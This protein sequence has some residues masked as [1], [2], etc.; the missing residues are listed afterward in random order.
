ME[1]GY[2]LSIIFAICALAVVIS[3]AMRYRSG[4]IDYLDSDA[5]WHTLL[6][7]ECYNETPISQHLFLPIVSLGDADD[8]GIPWGA[9]IPDV[10]GNYYYTSFSPMGYF[11]P[12]LF[13]KIFHLSASER[14]LYIFNTLLFLISTCLL[15][16]LISIIYRDNKHELILCLSGGLLYVFMPEL[17]HGMGM[18]YWHQSVLQV[19]LLLQ[20]IAF[21]KYAV[22]GE[23]AY[24]WLFY[25]LAVFNPYTEWTGY[26]AN[27]GFAFAELILYWKESKKKA[28]GRAM[29]L[30]ALTILAF[31]LFSAHY[32]L[33]TDAATYFMA[34]KNRFMARNVTTDV[35]ILSVIKGY[36]DSFLY[37]WL[38]ALALAIWVCVQNKK[39]EVHE[40]VL[41][42]VMAFPVLENIIMKEHAISYTYDRMKAAWVLV[43]LLCE[44]IRN[45]LDAD[46]RRIMAFGAMGLVCLTSALNLHSYIGNISYIWQV[47]YRDNN[48]IL[49]D[50]VTEQY[51][52]ALYAANSSIRGYMNLLFERGIWEGCDLDRAKAIASERGKN[53]I[54]FIQESGYSVQQ[55][56]VYECK[57]D[58][59]LTQTSYKIVDGEVI[60]N[61]DALGYQLANMTDANWT[62]GC[63]NS[64]N[65]ILFIR[66]NELLIDL[67]THSAIVTE[68][69]SHAILGIDYDAN[70]IRVDVDGD[71]WNL[72]YPASLMIE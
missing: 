54:V 35:A 1:G 28:F 65:T 10:E 39:I 21:Y 33:R 30:A 49:A 36:L 25:V 23:K 22:L 27:V 48:K 31:G 66:D 20:I 16:W 63:S 8:K 6:T 68:N 46:G 12:W 45:L 3:A 34:L 44:L 67:L 43:L 72:Q 61:A 2:Q 37:I 24:R 50:Y 4:E 29:I 18:V 38:L 59:I 40:G 64:A 62:G 53:T 55:I 11:L 26:V 32:L 71:I 69:E 42:L 19:T 58:E 70:W 56:D 5:T 47:D 9:T 17:M 57:D 52:D 51:P 60:E 15:V 41:F 14:S 13:I 7:I